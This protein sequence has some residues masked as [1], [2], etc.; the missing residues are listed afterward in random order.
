MVV[1]IHKALRKINP[2]FPIVGGFYMLFIRRPNR[3][4][5]TRIGNSGDL[6]VVRKYISW[7]TLLLKVLLECYMC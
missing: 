5:D 4:F 6:C 1:F 3:L 2:V 7:V